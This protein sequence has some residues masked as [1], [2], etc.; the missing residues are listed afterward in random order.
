M[1]ANIRPAS[2]VNRKFLEKLLRA[3]LPSS[4]A[5]A[6]KSRCPAKDRRHADHR[7]I[8]VALTP[9]MAGD[10]R[11]AVA[12]GEYA[13]ASEAIR[14]AVR[15]WQERRDL[16]GFSADE[17]RRLVEEGLASGQSPHASM[18]DVKAE[19]RRRWAAL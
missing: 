18:A 17:L 12:A 9:E 19:A 4:R 14:A 16:L 3:G 5:C 6:L 15:E 2:G 8:T 11:R 13:S 1:R 10:V 7:E